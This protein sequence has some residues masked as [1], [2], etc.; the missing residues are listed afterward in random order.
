MRKYVN[1]GKCICTKTQLYT[2]KPVLNSHSKRRP[3]FGFS[4]QLWLNAGQEYCRMLQWEH[5][6]ILSTFIKLPFV[7]TIFILSFMEWPIKTGFT[8]DF[9]HNRP[10]IMNSQ[11]HCR[12]KKSLVTFHCYSIHL[13]QMII[14]LFY[15]IAKYIS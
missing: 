9:F 10:M 13:C 12:N 5:S 3:K 2:V 15:I 11:L 8:V 4:D 1:G 6:A 14:V 7:I